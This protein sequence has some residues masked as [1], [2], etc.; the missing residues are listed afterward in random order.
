MDNLHV[1]PRLS[2]VLTTVRTVRVHVLTNGFPQS[3]SCNPPC[4]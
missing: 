3:P 2:D 4:S 1:Y